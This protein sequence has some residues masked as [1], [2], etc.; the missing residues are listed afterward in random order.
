LIEQ[1]ASV[2]HFHFIS[3]ILKVLS[4]LSLVS[5]KVISSLASSTYMYY[6]PFVGIIVFPLI[7]AW[8]TQPCH[9]PFSWSSIESAS[10]S[11]NSSGP[12]LLSKQI[13]LYFLAIYLMYLGQALSLLWRQTPIV[14]F[15]LF[16][17][18]IQQSSYSSLLIFS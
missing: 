9:L 16:S 8:N 12:I 13:S 10:R 5:P 14:F 6:L 15:S 1:G 18:S 2:L 4:T 17:Y 7:S 11:F 3:Q